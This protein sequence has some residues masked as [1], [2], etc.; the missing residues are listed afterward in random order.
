MNVQ[1]D[2]NRET[3]TNA[4]D[5]KKLIFWY[6]EGNIEV[7]IKTIAEICK[8]DEK[9]SI[10]IA[11]DSLLDG[12]AKIT[13]GSNDKLIQLQKAFQKHLITTTIE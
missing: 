12:S 5:S 9:E 2:S 10:Q 11:L 7:K 8:I 3:L 6:G 1:L 13:T 4:T